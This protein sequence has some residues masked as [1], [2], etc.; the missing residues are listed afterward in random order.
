MPSFHLYEHSCTIHMH[1]AGKMLMS[2]KI[3]RNLKNLQIIQNRERES[4]FQRNPF[5]Y[6]SGSQPWKLARTT[7]REIQKSLFLKIIF[8]FK[9]CMFLCVCVHTRTYTRVHACVCNMHIQRPQEHV[10][11]VR[12]SSFCLFLKLVYYLTISYIYKIHSEYIHPSILFYPFLSPPY[13]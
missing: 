2:I 5:L 4:R 10:Q 8:E 6:F 3:K 9:K 13:F 1:N 12:V 11:Y 7:G